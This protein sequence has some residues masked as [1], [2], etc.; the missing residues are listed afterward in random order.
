MIAKLY[1]RPYFFALFII[2]GIRVIAQTKTYVGVKMGGGISTAFVQHSVFPIVANTKWLP[3]FHGGLQ[4]THFP[5]KF[6]SKLNMGIQIGVNYAQKGWVQTFKGTSEP[7][8]KTRIHYLEVPVEAIG[9]FGD[10][11]KYYVSVGFYMEYALRAIV[12][13][14]PAS[15]ATNPD[16]AIKTLS[17]G[18]STFYRY[19]LNE[20]NRLNYGPRGAIGVIRETNLGV[21][22][23]EAFFSFSLRS[24]YDYESIETGIPDL[25]LNYGTGV[26]IFYMVSFGKLSF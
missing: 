7:N 25:A 6:K 16:T 1:M 20:G 11:N 4:V 19:I 26:S 14:T 17:V 8:H 22:R 10:K 2:F 13:S 5:E 21:F 9:Y 3:N 15:A 23:L 24:V 18:Q 12:D